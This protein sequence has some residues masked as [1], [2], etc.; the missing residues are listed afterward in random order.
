PRYVLPARTDA[1]T[2]P[3]AGRANAD[4]DTRAVIVIAAALD[5]A[6]ARRVAV[7]ILYDH[8]ARA[9]LA[10]A[11]AVFVADHA[12]VL[13]AIVGH[14]HDAVGERGRRRGG[15]EQRACAEC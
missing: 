6:L 3:H 14:R 9:A 2:D 4:A 11:T 1:D 7:G 10:P 8:A 15:G 5:V 12:D 13:D